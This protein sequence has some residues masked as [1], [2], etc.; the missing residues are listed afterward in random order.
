VLRKAILVVGLA[1]LVGAAGAVATLLWQPPGE[2]PGLSANAGGS[3]S[4]VAPAFAQ[5]AGKSFLET[6]A[7][8]SVYAN[9]GQAINLAKATPLYRV[10]EDQTDSYLIGT[11]ELSGYG[12]DWWPHVWID[13]DGW[14]VVYY[15]KAEPTSRLMH[16]YVYK[17]DQITTTT[18]REVLFSVAR[19]LAADI[20]RVESGMRYYHWQ[21]PDSTKMLIVVDTTDAGTDTFKYT[22]PAGLTLDEL[23]GSH[24]G[25]GIGYYGNGWSATDIDGTRFQ[26]G[27]EGTYILVGLLPDN[28]LVQGVPHVVTTSH[29]SGWAG[30]ALF[31]L[32]R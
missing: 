9:I 13:K 16:W 5:A 2:E 4:L 20:V 8:I 10:L 3:L 15:P 1:I 29:K 7:G 31:F 27:G 23:T 32:Y 14:I 19:Q 24:Y 17:R 11:V 6:E 26:G 30:F 21:R 18:L 28:A 25:S 22:V 12:E